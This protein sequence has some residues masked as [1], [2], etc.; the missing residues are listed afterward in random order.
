MP[1]RTR[2][3]IVGG[4]PPAIFAAVTSVTLGRLPGAS[5]LLIATDAWLA[6]A[7]F[8]Y[9]RLWWRSGR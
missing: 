4:C 1:V 5:A 3:A 2:G 8:G 7:L 9:L 6:G